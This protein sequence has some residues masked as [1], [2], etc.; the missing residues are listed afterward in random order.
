MTPIFII[1]FN[2][3]TMLKKLIDRL[4]ELKQERIIIIDNK[5]SYQPLLQYYS[6]IKNKF[7]IIYMPNNYGH[8]VISQVY[9]DQKFKDKY[10]LD[11][12]NFVYTDCDVVPVKECPDDFMEKFSEVLKRYPS[13]VKVGFGLKMDDLPNCFGGKKWVLRRQSRFWKRKIADKNLGIDLYSAPI[14][15]TFSYRRANTAPGKDARSFRTGAPYLARHLPWYINSEKLSKEDRYYINT[16][17]K[18]RKSK[19]SSYFVHLKLYK[20]GSGN[21]MTSV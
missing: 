3:Y 16:V 11:K 20:K 19:V 10:E 2:R 15:T 6:E 4:V 21:Q 12:V 14:D 1:S 9:R 18:S 13:I 5:S 7:E 8:H 17:T